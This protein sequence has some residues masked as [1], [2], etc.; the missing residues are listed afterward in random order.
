M[1]FF[2]KDEYTYED[3][4]SLINNDAEESLNLEFKEARAL[5]KDDK[6]KAEITKDVSAF[7]NSDGGIIIYGIQEKAHKASHITFIDGNEFTKEWLELVINSGINRKIPNL[8]IYPI[9]KDGDIKQTIYLIKIPYSIEAPHMNKEKLYYKRFNFQSVK[10]EEYEVRQL[11]Y[12]KKKA[13]LEIAESSLTVCDN[14]DIDGIKKVQL[15]VFITNKGEVLEKDYKTEMIIKNKSIP[16]DDLIHEIHKVHFKAEYVAIWDRQVE[17]V[18]IS[19]NNHIGGTIFQGETLLAAS[20]ILLIRK[21]NW[22]SF[23]TSSLDVNILY[24]SKIF[25]QREIIMSDILKV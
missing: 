22:V 5:S 1:E 17:R 20:V 19:M 10:M 2:N 12:R 21:E 9:H 25:I 8:K 15:S 7:A 18:I 11:Y 3:I 23:L 14:Q 13:I 4:E 16:F 24:S 6:Y